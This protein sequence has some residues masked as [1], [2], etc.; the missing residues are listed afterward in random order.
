MATR[1]RPYRNMVAIANGQEPAASS[2]LFELSQANVLRM[3]PQGQNRRFEKRHPND[4][5]LIGK[6]TLL[7][8]TANGRFWPISVIGGCSVGG[9]AR[10]SCPRIR[11]QMSVIGAISSCG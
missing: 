9:T 5:L 2:C 6:K 7:E 11:F 4:R 10:S 3:S 1:L 8:P